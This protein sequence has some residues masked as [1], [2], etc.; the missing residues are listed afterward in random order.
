MLQ[1]YKE[2]LGA[3]SLL[4]QAQ[5]CSSLTKRQT[6]ISVT[7]DNLSTTINSVEK[8]NKAC[9]DLGTLLAYKHNQI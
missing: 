5:R 1:K 8:N 7:I 3:C 4:L 6:V 2:L 9:L